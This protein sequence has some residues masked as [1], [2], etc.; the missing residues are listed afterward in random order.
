MAEPFLVR[1]P[2]G[3]DLVEAITRVFRER[4]I[5][6]AAFNVIGAVTRA[7]LGY[8]DASF[9]YVNREFPGMQEIASCMGNVSEKEGDVF[10]HAHIVLSGK[11]YQCHA[12]HVMPG[13]EIF[14][15]ELFAIPVAGPILVRNFDEPTGLA[16]WSETE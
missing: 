3:E 9:Q 12:G 6:K 13:T 7:T 4:S 8:Y 1:L 15:A 5:R 11:D 10:V 2:K 14:A 16:L